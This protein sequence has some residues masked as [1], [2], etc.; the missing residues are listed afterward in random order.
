MFVQSRPSRHR[1]ASIDYWPVAVSPLSG[2][3]LKKQTFAPMLADNRKPAIQVVAGIAH[4]AARTL[5]HQ[6]ETVLCFAAVRSYARAALSAPDD[7][8][9]ILPLF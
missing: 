4:L 8:G 6:H 1:R 2:T 5:T 3:D 9:T 7:T